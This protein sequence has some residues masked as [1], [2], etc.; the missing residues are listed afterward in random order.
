MP[1]ITWPEKIGALILIAPMLIIGIK[2]D[3]LMNWI[4]PALES[5]LFQAAMNAVKGGL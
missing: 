2:P 1:P 5:P 3:L 4:R